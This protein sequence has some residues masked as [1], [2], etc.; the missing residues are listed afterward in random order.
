M[1]GRIIIKKNE[2]KK[3]KVGGGGGENDDD[4]EEEEEGKKMERRNNNDILCQL[5]EIANNLTEK[6]YQLDGLYS[7]I[8]IDNYNNKYIIKKDHLFFLRKTIDGLEN[9]RGEL[10]KELDILDVMMMKKKEFYNKEEEIEKLKYMNLVL[11][12]RLDE[13]ENEDMC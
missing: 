4:E 12:S 1:L 11:R 10:N 9:L 3:R 8:W 13:Y 7:K 2:Q 6:N 5:K